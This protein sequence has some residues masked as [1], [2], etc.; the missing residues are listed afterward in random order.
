MYWL[1][2]A[3]L[4]LGVSGHLALWIALFN[5]VHATGLPQR[6]IKATEKIHVLAAVIVPIVWIYRLA[7]MSV[8]RDPVATI[9]EGRAFESS[10]FVVCCL[11]FTYLGGRWSWRRLREQRPDRL[12]SNHDR[13]YD[14]RRELGE[15]LVGGV[16]ANLLSVVPG[17]QM[18][19]ICVNEKEVLIGRLAPDLD[20]LSIAHLSDLHFT[21]KLTREYFDFVIDRTN[22]LDADLIV[23]TGDVVDKDHCVDWIPETLGRLQARIG[24]YFIL[25]NHDKRVSD[26]VALRETLAGCGFIDLG[27]RSES[28]L[29]QG[30]EVLLAGNERPWFDP[31]PDIPPR[32]IEADDP[33][34]RILLSHSP[35]QI[36]WAQQHEFDLM[37]AGHTHGGQI[38]FPL[39]GP[40][41]APSRFGVKYASGVFYEPPTLIHVS[42]GISG[43]DPIRLN[44]LPELTK[45]VLRSALVESTDLPRTA[46]LAASRY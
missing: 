11:F 31:L 22:E 33:A 38:R 23:V 28:I 35:D 9:F 36:Q 10:Y 41:V 19:K 20:G 13:V 43:L 37:L 14:V 1:S 3:L 46:E 18:R 15:R 44:C 34:V 8:P 16:M 29:I 4:L 2:S 7:T 17:N 12:I 39:I 30:C 45:L 5:R 21:G 26:V 6:V 40:V 42:R 27:G 25:G 32:E 24:M